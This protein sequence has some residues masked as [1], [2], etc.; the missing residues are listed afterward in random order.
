MVVL[1]GTRPAV[2]CVE[3]VR[4][5]EIPVSKEAIDAQKGR[6]ARVMGKFGY[7]RAIILLLMLFATP[8]LAIGKCGSGKRVTCVVDGDTIWFKGEKIRMKNYDTPEPT[9]NICGGNRERKLA[10]RA[11]KRL[12]QLLNENGFTIQRFGKDRY[13]RTIATIRVGGKDV[14]D[15]LIAEGLARRWPNGREFWCN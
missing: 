14:G 13:G 5:V 3:K 15:I 8:A 10:A 12:I 9:T 6:G 4:H 11:S 2:R 1:F 7:M